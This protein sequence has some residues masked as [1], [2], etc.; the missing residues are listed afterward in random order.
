VKTVSII[1]LALVP[2]LFACFPQIPEIHLNEVPAG[3]LLRALDQRRQA[4][5]GLTGMAVVRVERKGRKRTFDNVGIALSAQSGLRMEA[6]GPLGQSLITLVWDGQEIQLRLPG[7]DS[8]LTPG[9]AGLEKLLGVGL[10]PTELAAALSGNVP[11]FD[12]SAVIKA[13]CAQ[14]GDCVVEV[15]QADMLRRITM[16]FPASPEERGGNIII[17][18]SALYR[19]GKLIFA[20]RFEQGEEVSKYVMPKNIVFRDPDKKASFTV[21]YSEVEVNGAIPDKAF[22]L[23]NA[24]GAGP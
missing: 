20:A 6:F 8:I 7:Q 12:Q 24:E 19:S 1:T 9:Q 22:S 10:E 17:I 15:R 11:E 2:L 14:G 13:F 23:I 16:A 5:A 18:E 3:P 4:F 21:S